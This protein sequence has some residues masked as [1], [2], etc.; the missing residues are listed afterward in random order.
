MPQV[1]PCAG[2]IEA[3]LDVAGRSPVI[4]DQTVAGNSGEAVELVVDGGSAVERVARQEPL[5]ED[6]RPDGEVVVFGRLASEP[7]VQ[8]SVHLPA[9][10][11]RVCRVDV[12]DDQHVAAAVVGLEHDG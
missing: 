12:M 8:G 6:A 11:R 9:D 5:G 7:A 4:A 10:G 3:R 2:V 1:F